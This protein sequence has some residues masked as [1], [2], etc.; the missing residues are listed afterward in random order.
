MLAPLSQD[1]FALVFCAT[2]C[3]NKLMC[4]SERRRAVLDVAGAV[5]VMPDVA[6][7][8]TTAPLPAEPQELPATT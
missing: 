1:T 6:P 4:S 7:A 5:L 2:S 8:A 3:T